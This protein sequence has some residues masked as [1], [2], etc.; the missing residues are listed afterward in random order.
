MNKDP[1]P[2]N[3]ESF[4]VTAVNE[5][6]W[7]LLPRESGSVDLAQFQAV[8]A[9]MLQGSSWINHQF[10]WQFGEKYFKIVYKTF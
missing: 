9:T 8:Q 6:I 7:D 5:K 4:S 2:E 3:C 10:G 1:S